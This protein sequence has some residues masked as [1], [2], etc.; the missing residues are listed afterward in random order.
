MRNTV[1]SVLN[2][3]SQQYI[4]QVFTTFASQE[5]RIFGMDTDEHGNIFVTGY[6]QGSGSLFNATRYAISEP[7]LFAAKLN[8]YGKV[9]WSY[10]GPAFSF[11]HHI[12]FYRSIRVINLYGCFVGPSFTIWNVTIKHA[13]QTDLSSCQVFQLKLYDHMTCQACSANTY[14]SQEEH[15]QQ[16]CK[17]CPRNYFTLQEGSSNCTTCDVG[18]YVVS[19]TSR[20]QQINN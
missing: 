7:R 12:R 3:D 6:L 4:Q 9:M 19:A 1:P 8:G 13:S 2:L 5:S 18:Y 17:A 20:S 16:T 15:T 14:T 10:I 11:G